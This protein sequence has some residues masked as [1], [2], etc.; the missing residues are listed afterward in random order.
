MLLSLS[1]QLYFLALLSDKQIQLL[2]TLSE[3]RTD[4]KVEEQDR[5]S[6]TKTRMSEP[7]VSAIDQARSAAMRVG[8]ALQRP[9]VQ[10][11]FKLT[12]QNVQMNDSDVKMDFSPSCF[13]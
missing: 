4:L 9:E 7:V 13:S 6:T 12:Q 1:Q 2:Q 10:W 11:Q 8:I 5:E 3:S